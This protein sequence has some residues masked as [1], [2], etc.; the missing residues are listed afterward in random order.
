MKFS[1]LTGVDVRRRFHS[2]QSDVICMQAP[3]HVGLVSHTPVKTVQL[4]VVVKEDRG[5]LELLAVSPA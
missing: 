5:L 3:V 1:H 4:L 2:G